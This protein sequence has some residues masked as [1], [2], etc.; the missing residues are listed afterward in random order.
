[1]TTTELLFVALHYLSYPGY[2]R[3]V[4]VFLFGFFFS[5]LEHFAAANEEGE[6]KL[7]RPSFGGVEN[8]HKISL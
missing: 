4:W 2:S 7:K 1:M 8:L 6:K 3:N 5:C